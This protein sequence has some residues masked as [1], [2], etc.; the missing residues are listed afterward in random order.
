M[1]QNSAALA[2]LGA[3]AILGASCDHRANSNNKSSVGQNVSPTGLPPPC[4]HDQPPQRTLIVGSPKDLDW[5][6]AYGFNKLDF[7]QLGGD[8]LVQ[9]GSTDIVLPDGSRFFVCPH[10]AILTVDRGQADDLEF[11]TVPLTQSEVESLTRRTDASL[12]V[13]STAAIAA[14][15]RNLPTNPNVFPRQ[16]GL[17]YIRRGELVI[18][19][20]VGP[21]Y[22][23]THPFSISYFIDWEVQASSP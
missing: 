15:K 19:A 20:T 22:Y 14:W 23:A 2:V 4:P 18:G 11:F 13:D 1:T 6:V 9:P 17:F 5:L 3:F 21:S 10:R 16:E 12:K 7:A 8:D